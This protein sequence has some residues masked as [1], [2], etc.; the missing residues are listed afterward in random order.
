MLINKTTI[1]AAVDVML[2]ET[3]YGN[4]ADLARGLNIADST[5]RTTI[6][7]GTL[8]VAD[9]IKIADMLGYSVIIERKG[10]QHG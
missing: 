3:Q 4:V 2:A 6:N 10:A 1:K 8:R 9:L 7:R 5:L